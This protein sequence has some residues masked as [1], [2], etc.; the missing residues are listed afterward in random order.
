[1]RRRWIGIVFGIRVLGGAGA[2]WLLGHN[3]QVQTGGDYS[4]AQ[5]QR[6]DLVTSVAATGKVTPMVGAEVRVGSRISG[7]VQRLLANIGDVVRA[8][9]VIAE[10]E[11][12]DLLAQLG[13][14]QAELEIAETRLSSVQA[15]GPKEILKAEAVLSDAKANREL[16]KIE[17]SRQ[18]ELL[19]RGLV[20]RQ[21][22][23]GA[24]R[25]KEVTE[26]RV[27]VAGRALELARQRLTEDSKSAKAQLNQA[28]AAVKVVQ[29][30]LAYGTI[31]APIP[32]VISSVSTQEGETVAAGFNSPTFVTIIDLGKLQVDAYVDETDIGRIQVGQKATFTV[33]SYP[34]RDFHG[35]VAAIY[36][37]AVIVDNVVYYDVVLN[38]DEP[39]TGRLRPEMTTNVVIEQEARRG[40]LAVPARAVTR[41]QGK[42]VVYVQRAGETAPQTVKLGWKDSQWVE[43]VEGLRETDRVRVRKT[44]RRNGGK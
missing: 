3:N 28:R 35:L 40:V 37:K 44:A 39:L 27:E 23:D 4:W 32:G 11:R 15:L 20:P 22:L 34:D 9:Q 2:W 43:I 8:G 12:S 30:Q 18:S 14:R 29:A 17:F 42:P 31:R 1:M 38:I 7:R 33:D 21:A 24:R 19:K 6:R 26:A 10:L 36:P 5:A 25:E 13:Q 16:A 41:E